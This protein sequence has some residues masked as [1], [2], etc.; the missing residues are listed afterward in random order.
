MLMAIPFASTTIL[1]QINQSWILDGM[2][3][4]LLVKDCIPLQPTYKR[5][6]N[7][8]VMIYFTENIWIIYQSVKAVTRKIY[9]YQFGT[10][11]LSI[12]L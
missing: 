1:G 3:W 9:C 10:S 12:F 5:T 6:Y 7:Y 11:Q 4:S 8:Y 2:D